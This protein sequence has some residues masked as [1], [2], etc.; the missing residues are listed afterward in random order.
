MQGLTKS[1]QIQHIFASS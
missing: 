1:F